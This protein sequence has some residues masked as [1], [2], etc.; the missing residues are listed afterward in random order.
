[1]SPQLSDREFLTAVEGALERAATVER[2]FLPMMK[3]SEGSVK[4]RLGP[5]IP[6][7]RLRNVAE[8]LKAL[9]VH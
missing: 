3:L 1:M 6:G 9:R 5:E 2:T 7:E 4:M 8:P